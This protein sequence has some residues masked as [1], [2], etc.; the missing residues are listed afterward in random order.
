MHSY[1]AY[2]WQSDRSVA[3]GVPGE[4][5]FQEHNAG[6]RID[7]QGT[8]AAPR[9][10]N[11]KEMFF[12]LLWKTKSFFWVLLKITDKT[13]A[14]DPGTEGEKKPWHQG[15]EKDSLLV[16]NVSGVSRRQDSQQRNHTE[17]EWK[18]QAKYF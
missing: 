6:D 14:G 17:T 3:P 7:P 2:R 8:S 4:L 18:V 11:V 9:A 15:L 16:E 13:R 12:L 10:L 5:S 1:C